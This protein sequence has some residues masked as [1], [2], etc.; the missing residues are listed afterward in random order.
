MGLELGLFDDRLTL[1]VDYYLD[2]SKDLIAYKSVSSVSG[3]TG[4]YVNYADVRNQGIDVSLSGTLLK[5][6]DWRWTAAFNMGYVKNKV[7]KSKSTAQ[8]KYL[9]QSVYTPGE[10]YEGKPVNGMFSI[11]FCQT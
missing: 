9:V 1:D 11:S 7:T 10:V 3:F 8:T 5:N 2:E 6:K 4:K